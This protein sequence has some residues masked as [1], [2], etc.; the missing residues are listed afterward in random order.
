MVTVRP[1]CDLPALSAGRQ[2]RSQSRIEELS[3]RVSNPFKYV[4]HL[5]S[6]VF[7]RQTLNVEDYTSQRR[8][9][10]L[11]EGERMKDEEKLGP[12]ADARGQV[13]F[14]RPSG[15]YSLFSFVSSFD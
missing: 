5:F 3:L 9:G 13:F 6:I 7:G 10:A 15:P 11:R 14:C 4:N 1:T 12:G 2:L 8:D